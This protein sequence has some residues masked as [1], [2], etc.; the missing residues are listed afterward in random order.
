MAKSFMQI[1]WMTKIITNCD[2]QT[3]Y[4]DTLILVHILMMKMLIS[5]WHNHILS[6]YPF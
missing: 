5:D 6:Q 2:K 4:Q 1:H 3:N